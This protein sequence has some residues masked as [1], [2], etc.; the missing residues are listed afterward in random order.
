MKKPLDWT[1]PKTCDAYD[2]LHLRKLPITQV[3]STK[4]FFTTAKRL[5]LYKR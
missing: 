5:R 4:F 3:L 1:L 2:G